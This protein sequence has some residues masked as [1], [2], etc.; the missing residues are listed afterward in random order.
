[1]INEAS[2]KNK[3]TVGRKFLHL[4]VRRDKKKGSGK[5]RN[6]S[7]AL[8]AVDYDKLTTQGVKKCV[9]IEEKQGGQKELI[10]HN[11]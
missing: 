10:F 11:I 6:I 4:Q 1:M 7:W 8:A 9:V 3:I 5:R 2:E